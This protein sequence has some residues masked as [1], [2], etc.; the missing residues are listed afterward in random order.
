[1]VFALLAGAGR[2]TQVEA[3]SDVLA[4]Q[5]FST[6]SADLDRMHELELFS[7]GNVEGSNGQPVAFDSATARQQGFSD[8]SIRLGK[9]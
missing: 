8:S 2:M 9:N 1:M 5:D 3:S 7:G 4:S 6:L